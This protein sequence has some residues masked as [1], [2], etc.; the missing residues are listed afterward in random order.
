MLRQ[1]PAYQ[2][3]SSYHMSIMATE[4]MPMFK[5]L[6]NKACGGYDE[7][8]QE[9][10]ENLDMGDYELDKMSLDDPAMVISDDDME[11]W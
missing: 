4:Y 6:G 7:L 1:N 3:L 8:H 5:L 2:R 10:V 11:D 9:S